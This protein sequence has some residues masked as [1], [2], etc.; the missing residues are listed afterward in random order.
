MALF[1]ITYLQGQVY[2]LQVFECIKVLRK[3][4]TGYLFFK[5]HW[6]AYTCIWQN[7]SNYVHEGGEGGYHL[8]SFTLPPSG[9]NI[10]YSSW[11]QNRMKIPWP[12]LKKLP[13]T[14]ST[15]QVYHKF[16][17]STHCRKKRRGKHI[18]YKKKKGGGAKNKNPA[19][20]R[21]VNLSYI[22]RKDRHATVNWSQY[23]MWN[24]W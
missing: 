12:Y 24:T 20:G 3:R 13:N 8:N 6:P 1:W 10:K 18:F 11:N 2:R 15:I 19:I 4:T 17:A 22:F 9:I 21:A 14:S 7:E 5:S 16:L 23:C